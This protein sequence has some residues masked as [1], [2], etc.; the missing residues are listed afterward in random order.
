MCLM[1]LRSIISITMVQVSCTMAC[2]GVWLVS[3]MEFY[4][5]PQASPL[6]YTLSLPF[7]ITKLLIEGKV[8]ELHHSLDIS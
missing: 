5:F 4:V 2:A 3:F 7:D 1:S 6:I 8:L